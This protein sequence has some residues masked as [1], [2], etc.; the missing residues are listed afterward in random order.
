MLT[1]RGAIFIFFRSLLFFFCSAQVPASHDINLLFSQPLRLFPQ[2]YYVSLCFFLSLSL[3]L[4]VGTERANLQMCS[5]SKSDSR[6]QQLRPDSGSKHRCRRW[7][8]NIRLHHCKC[9]G[10]PRII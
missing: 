6:T 4:A 10:N 1:S 5:G 2:T 9:V 3:T 8:N 7:L